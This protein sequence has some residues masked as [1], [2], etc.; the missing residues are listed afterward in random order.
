MGDGGLCVGG[1]QLAYFKKLEI[2]NKIDSM[3]LG[4]NFQ[5]SKLKKK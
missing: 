4:N 3:Y 2:P 1:A 5:R